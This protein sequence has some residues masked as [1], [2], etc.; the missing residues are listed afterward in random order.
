MFSQFTPHCVKI[1]EET[2]KVQELEFWNCIDT[3]PVIVID[4]DKQKSKI[5][6]ERRASLGPNQH[7]VHGEIEL[8]PNEEDEED[9]NITIEQNLE[10]TTIMLLVANQKEY[11][12]FQ[13]HEVIFEKTIQ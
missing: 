11:R 13:S 9:D 12:W 2:I 7:S 4:I 8:D 6:K 10:I 3:Y 1:K 5:S